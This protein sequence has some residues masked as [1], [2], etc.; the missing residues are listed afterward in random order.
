MSKDIVA[1]TGEYTNREGET[2][3]EWTKIGVVLSNQN[4]EYILL[5]PSINLSGVLQKQNMLAV[6]Q[7]KAGN[8][9]ARTGKAVMCSIFDR[10]QQQ[11]G[12]G[13]Q[14]SAPQQRT[15]DAPN[16]FADFDDDIP[17]N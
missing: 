10:D 5:D 4:G 15:Q 9:K 12:Q 11:G 13:Q 3:S 8:E 6:E 17:F 2:K 14:A 16:D 7:R 1:K